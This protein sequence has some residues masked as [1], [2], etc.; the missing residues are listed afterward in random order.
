MWSFYWVYVIEFMKEDIGEIKGDWMKCWWISLKF[1]C[2]FVIEV[3][4]SSICNKDKY[5]VVRSR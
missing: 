3:L 5:V 2:M 4:N 1:Y